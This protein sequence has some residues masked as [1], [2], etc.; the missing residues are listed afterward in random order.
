M[1]CGGG[2]KMTPYIM[3]SK[4]MKWT[5]KAI[6]QSLFGVGVKYNAIHVRRALGHTRIDRRTAKHY[7]ER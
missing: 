7:I 3:F 5:A 2:E 6:V 4:K 1:C